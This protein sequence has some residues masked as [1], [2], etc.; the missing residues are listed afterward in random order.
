MKNSILTI[1]LSLMFA[2]CSQLSNLTNSSSTTNTNSESN[3]KSQIAVNKISANEAAQKVKAG[4]L[5]VDVRT[6]EEVELGGIKGA[7]NINS[8][9]ADKRTTEF[10][11]NKNREIV[12]FCR[13]GRRA[14]HVAQM[15]IKN[16]YSKV[17]NAGGYS[18]L[19]DVLN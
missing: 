9:E 16:G 12:L 1:S 7:K 6:P 13:S 10:G 14:D 4:A 17:Y 2:G 3:T 18:D 19:K 8:T 11:S 5:L 15:L